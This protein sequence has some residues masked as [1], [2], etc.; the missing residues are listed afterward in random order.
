M[1]INL[2]EIWTLIDAYNRLSLDGTEIKLKKIVRNNNPFLCH[3]QEL[4]C[5]NASLSSH[6]TLVN[7]FVF[8]KKKF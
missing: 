6:E 5:P 2:S 7:F 8:F 4:K 1:N 3:E